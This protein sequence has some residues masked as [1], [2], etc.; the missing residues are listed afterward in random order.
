MVLL[1]RGF[2]LIE[3]LIVCAI[4]AILASIAVPNFL[5]AQTRAKTSRV[6]ADMR[7][8]A[9]ALEAYN[10]DT[11]AYPVRHDFWD[12]QDA[13]ICPE[14]ERSRAMYAPFTS[15]VFDPLPGHATAS[16]G[17]HVLTTPISYIS[18]LPVDVFNTPA[19][20]L[21]T[22]PIS[23]DGHNFATH[24]GTDGID[25]WDGIQVAT[26]VFH[27]MDYVQSADT[28]STLDALA[29]TR[30]YMLVSVGPDRYFGL[31]R[32]ESMRRHV[33]GYP[34]ETPE[35]LTT[36]R[37]FYDPTN[38]TISTGNIYR[39]ASERARQRCLVYLR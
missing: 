5:D 9:T 20:T 23:G 29:G 27:L 25:Y 2:T 12:E 18:S 33:A 19:R 34:L 37:F 36:E 6:K 35:T 22:Q 38:G 14:P 31:H 15:K 21:M 32:P 1:K 10:V 17:M 30:G 3:L 11:N 26:W 24:G 13:W 8:I 16:V 4:I 39:F 28:S 7:T